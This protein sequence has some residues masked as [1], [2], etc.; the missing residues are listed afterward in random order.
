MNGSE[1]DE[2]TLNSCKNTSKNHASV[3]FIKTQRYAKYRV[4]S[5]AQLSNLPSKDLQIT[6]L[7]LLPLNSLKQTLEVPRSKTIKVIPLN[8][9][10]KHRRAIH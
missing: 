8:N 3:I 2:I 10:N 5:E 1:H 7:R 6:S 9:F 4:P